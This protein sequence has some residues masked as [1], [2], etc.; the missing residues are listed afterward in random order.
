MLYLS[1]GNYYLKALNSVTRT[2]W[3]DR[4][5]GCEGERVK[6]RGGG[7]DGGGGEEGETD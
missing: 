7:E 6:G 4:E 5:A 3:M 2:R 1:R